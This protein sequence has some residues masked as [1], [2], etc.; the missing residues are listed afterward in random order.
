MSVSYLIMAVFC[1]YYFLKQ[2]KLK[3]SADI[4]II[5]ALCFCMVISGWF[6]FLF[7]SPDIYNLLVDIKR[8]DGLSWKNIYMSVEIL[9][10]LTVGKNGIINIYNWFISRNGWHGAIIRHNSPHNPGI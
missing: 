8:G 9:A 7:V 10:L 3:A 2:L 4:Y 6:N 5:G 1:Y